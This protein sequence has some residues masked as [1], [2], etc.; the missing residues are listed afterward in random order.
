MFKL[1]GTEEF[2]IKGQD[3]S[4]F[5]KCE[6]LINACAGFTYEYILYVNGKQFKTFREKQSKIMHSWHF[7]LND[8][9]WR[10]IL[11]NYNMTGFFFKFCYIWTVSFSLEKDTL[12]IW[13]NGQKIDTT[14]EFVEDGTEITF[15]LEVN[16]KGCI[17]TV[18]SGNKKKGIVYVLEIDNVKMPESSE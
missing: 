1:V 15:D 6:V 14:H 5:A 16:T 7:Q 18:S 4:V 2:E 3:G 11:G 13:V 12:D 10:I 9:E 8:K 17:K